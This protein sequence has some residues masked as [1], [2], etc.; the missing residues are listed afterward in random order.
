MYK[1]EDCGTVFAEPKIIAESRGE[2]F[3]FPSYE[4]MAYC[5]NCTGDFRELTKEEEEYE[6]N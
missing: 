6:R 1:C 4:E 3:G 5:P 2:W